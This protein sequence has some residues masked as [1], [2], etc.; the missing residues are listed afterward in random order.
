M[1]SSEFDDMKKQA[2][3]NLKTEAKRLL[4]TQKLKLANMEKILVKDQPSPG[5]IYF[6]MCLDGCLPRCPNTMKL[7]KFALLIPP[8]TS[9]AECGFPTVNLLVSPSRTIVKWCQC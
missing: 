2:L 3:E 6:V 9:E 7:F 4:T 1:F 5:N 8:T